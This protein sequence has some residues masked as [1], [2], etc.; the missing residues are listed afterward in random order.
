M[1]DPS[2]SFEVFVSNESFKFNAAHFVA[3]PNF[4]ERLHGHNYHISV[5]LFGSHFIGRDGYVIDFGDVKD[6]TRTVCKRLNEHFLCPMYSDVIS[7]TKG[8]HS[9]RLFCEDGA[10][11]LFPSQDVAMLPIVH[12]TTEELAIYCWGEI[13]CQLN[14]DFLLKRGIHTM[15]VTCGEMI[16][17][18][19]VFRKKIP[20][21]DDPE[22]IR[23]ICD[24]RIYVS[25][26]IITTRLCL[27]TSD[28]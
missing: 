15:A 14:T 6:A 25:Q 11:F 27:P 18:E 17:Q 8:E 21:T 1:E 13:L 24:A 23:R 4:R 12:A 3:Y 20:H 22:E 28:N 10:E 16:G 9:V 2:N 19:A 26:G 5:R 7:I